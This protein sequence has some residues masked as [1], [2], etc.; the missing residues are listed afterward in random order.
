MSKQKNR[1]VN[2]RLNHTKNGIWFYKDIHQKT[3]SLKELQRLE[4][5]E[6]LRLVTINAPKHTAKTLERKRAK[7]A[8]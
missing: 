2:V 7:R 1:K 4:N 6:T 5:G 3:L 8:S